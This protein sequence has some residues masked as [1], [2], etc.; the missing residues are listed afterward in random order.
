MAELKRL[1]VLFV[2]FV[3]FLLAAY[4]QGGEEWRGP[5]SLRKSIHPK[6]GSIGLQDAHP[7]TEVVHELSGTYQRPS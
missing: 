3:A 6:G 2:A 7:P 1:L 4:I 5:H